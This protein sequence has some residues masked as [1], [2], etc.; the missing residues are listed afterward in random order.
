VGEKTY[1]STGSV[2]ILGVAITLFGLI[3][4][5]LLERFLPFPR[6]IDDLVSDRSM[7]LEIPVLFFCVTAITLVAVTLAKRD[8]AAQEKAT[9]GSRRM[10]L[11]VP[12]FVF[13]VGMAARMK[14][15][16]F[17]AVLLVNVNP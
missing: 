14:I 16:A 12:L 6:S 3:V 11:L 15:A 9:P 2:S 17:L 10:A 1:S 4:G 7:R 13:A 5:W 8:A